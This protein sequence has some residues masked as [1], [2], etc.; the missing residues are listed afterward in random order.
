MYISYYNIR[1]RRFRCIG[2]TEKSYQYTNIEFNTNIFDILNIQTVK[3][4]EWSQSHSTN[5][6]R[7][8]SMQYVLQCYV[9]PT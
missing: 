2:V 5:V 8:D 6:T 9:I 4:S 3:W 1:Y 7:V